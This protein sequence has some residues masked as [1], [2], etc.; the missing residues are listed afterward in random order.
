MSL[1]Q[2]INEFEVIKRPLEDLRGNRD[3]KYVSSDRVADPQSMQQVSTSPLVK[4]EWG[5]GYETTLLCVQSKSRSIKTTK[6]GCGHHC[7]RNIL[8]N[9]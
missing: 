1:T 7:V 8:R 6:S 2:H 4:A 3:E 9:E 5:G